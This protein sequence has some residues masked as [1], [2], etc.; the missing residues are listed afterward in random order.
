MPEK[1]TNIE[2]T[3]TTQSESDTNIKYKGDYLKI[4]SY[5]NMSLYLKHIWLLYY[6]ILEM[7]DLFY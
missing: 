3:G 6:H 4:I 2:K 7:M 5:K 1:F